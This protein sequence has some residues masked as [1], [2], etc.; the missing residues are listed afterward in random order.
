MSLSPGMVY[1]MQNCT[2]GYA[3]HAGSLFGASYRE[4]KLNTFIRH[5]CEVQKNVILREREREMVR[6]PLSVSGEETKI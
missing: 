6:N 4:K 3:E 1:F 5:I 2:C